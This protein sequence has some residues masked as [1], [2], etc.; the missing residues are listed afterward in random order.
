[1]IW[2]LETAFQRYVSLAECKLQRLT[3]EP[4]TS[5]KL[6]VLVNRRIEL[7]ALVDELETQ[8]EFKE[9]V[10]ETGFVFSKD[11][12][13]GE[14]KGKW[15]HCVQDFF[16]RSRVYLQL[17]K[18]KKVDVDRLFRKYQNSFQKSHVEITYIAPMELVQFAED[19]MDFGT[20]QIRKFGEGELNTLLQNDLNEIFYPWAVTDVKQLADYWFVIVKAPLPAPE[21]GSIRISSHPRLSVEYSPFEKP[22]AAAI[23]QLALFDWCP[24]Y[25]QDCNRRFDWD[26]CIIPFVL[27]SSSDLLERPRPAPDLDILQKRYVS[28]PETGEPIEVP[29]PMIFL[30]KEETNAFVNFV[31]QM[32]NL[33]SKLEINRGRWPFLEHGLGFLVKGFLTESMEQ[34]LWHVVAVESLLGKKEDR[35]TGAL[36]RRIGF[37][38]GSTEEEKFEE[39]WN[40]RCDLVHGN[41]ECTKARIYLMDSNARDIARKTIQWF[42]NYLDHVT[43][44]YKKHGPFPNREKI[45]RDLD[46]FKNLNDPNSVVEECRRTLP[47]GFPNVPGWTGIQSG[48]QRVEAKA[49]LEEKR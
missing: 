39:L 27:T 36:K 9:L 40:F 23:Q 33:V 48:E 19:S 37:I 26:R 24:V 46:S 49:L 11:C 3:E 35:G 22:L 32:E 12:S 5:R 31:R 34:L 16:R 2:K 14:I 30:T 44:V 21:P 18:L 43:A 45:L 6:T 10:K 20:F 1:M 42:L 41:P 15:K 29:E 8:S 28:D 7:K 25:H 47:K 38:L 13:R 4:R 17:H